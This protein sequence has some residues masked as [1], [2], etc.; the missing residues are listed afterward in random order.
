MTIVDYDH[1]SGHIS[2]PQVFAFIKD[3][4]T[5]EKVFIQ[6]YSLNFESLKLF[7]YRGSPD[8]KL[9]SLGCVDDRHFIALALGRELL[10]Y[11]LGE[12][13]MPVFK[14]TNQLSDWA[15][16]RTVPHVDSIAAGDQTGR[17]SLYQHIFEDSRK[18][19]R[20]DRGRRHFVAAAL[21][22]WHAH[23]VNDIAFSPSGTQMYSGSV[24]NVLV[25]WNIKNP[26]IREFTARI[27]SAIQHI[28]VSPDNQTVAVSLVDNGI[29]LVSSHMQL[30]A[31]IQKLTWCL[32]PEPGQT[33]LPAKMSYDPNSRCVV[34]NGRLGHL[35]FV[36]LDRNELQHSMDVCECNYVREPDTLLYLMQVVRVA[37]SEDGS[38]M[39]TVEMRDDHCTA[40]EVD[41]HIF[42]TTS[43]SSSLQT[44]HPALS[45]ASGGGRPKRDGSWMATVEMRDDHC[46]PGR[47]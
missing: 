40:R 23:P 43:N 13:G 15:V 1:D 9:L 38:W 47:C 24:E 34:L 42:L 16:V 27:Q 4:L 29:A 6:T 41:K 7:G 25:R 8:S 31:M 12:V 33:V 21:Y 10:V 2:Q 32:P 26:N 18:R 5:H 36:S 17:I 11:K 37:L 22:H 35:Q 39:A 19:K 28:T 3:N 30:Y 46:T 44:R 20:D 45:D 14:F